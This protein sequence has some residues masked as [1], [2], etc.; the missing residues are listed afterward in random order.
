MNS[1]EVRCHYFNSFDKTYCSGLTFRDRRVEAQWHQ[2]TGDEITGDM[3]IKFINRSLVVRMFELK[4]DT[5]S[6]FNLMYN[7]KK[8]NIVQLFFPPG[9]S[10]EV[11]LIFQ[12]AVYGLNHQAHLSLRD[13]A[14][15]VT[16]FATIWCDPIRTL[17]YA[18][19]F[20]PGSALELWGGETP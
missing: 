13:K 6:V 1:L 4:V 11:T 14:S 5:P 15:D 17:T 19:P 2:I 10:R 3:H 18:P 12:K 20:F 7:S 9:Q 8:G 16:T